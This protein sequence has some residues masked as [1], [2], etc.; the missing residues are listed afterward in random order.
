MLCEMCSKGTA[1]VKVDLEGAKLNVCDACSRYGKIIGRVQAPVKQ[2]SKPFAS[3]PVMKKSEKIQVIKTDYYISI[4]KA[5]EKLGI[6]QE[7]FAKRLMEKESMLHKIE[8]GHMKPDLELARKLE[9][10]LKIELVE[11]VEIEPSGHHADK[12]KKSEGLTLGDLIKLK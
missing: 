12:D 9:R 8:S 11:E 6:N 2:S 5:R 7:E 10:A 4:R 1:T 3:A